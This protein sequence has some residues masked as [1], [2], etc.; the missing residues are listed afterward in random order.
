MNKRQKNSS[1]LL[2]QEAIHSIS[3]VRN[4][5]ITSFIVKLIIIA[6][7]K[8]VDGKFLGGW[9]GADGENYLTGVN[10]LLREGYLSNQQELLFWPA[11]YPILIWFLCKISLDNVF[12]LVSLLQ[13]LFFAYSTF[14]FGRQLSFGKLQRYTY[15]ITIVLCF[16]PTLS[17]SSL[18]VGYESPIA[19]CMLLIIGL[20]IKY[21]RE[22]NEKKKVLII[23]AVGITFALTVFM[24]PRWILTTLVIAIYWALL[25]SQRKSQA[26]ILVGLMGIMSLAPATLITRNLAANKNAVIS[27]NLGATM[28]LGA[29]DTTSGGYL[30]SGPKVPCNS[31]T[32]S[33]TASDNELVGCVI[34]WYLEN[35]AKSVVLFAKKS[36]HFWS[37]WY[38]P[39]ANGTMAR[40]PWLEINPFKFLADSGEW[41]KSITFGLPGKVLS[42]LFMALSIVLLFQGFVWLYRQREIY[43]TI[44]YISVFPVLLSWLISMGTIGDHRFRVPTMGLSLFLQVVGMIII[45]DKLNTLRQEKSPKL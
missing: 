44:A 10:G 29:G 41:G 6:N 32:S 3:R 11:G 20:I 36:L 42:L 1:R 8:G 13:S 24:Q 33:Q 12:F 19:S 28:M 4:I 2:R 22:I 31:N 38:G 7:I 40:N 21:E 43:R 16:N 30:H 37:P 35:P 17:L 27:T 45:F 34:S 26:L 9:L 15:A 39:I 25:Q 23:C 14:F 5:V 18:T